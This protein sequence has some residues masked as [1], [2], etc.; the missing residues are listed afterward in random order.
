MPRPILIAALMLMLLFAAPATAFDFGGQL[1]YGD[2]SDIGV[3]GRVEVDTPEL[4]ERSR[5]AVDFNWYFPDSP[6]GGD[7][8]FWEIDL[9]WLYDITPE[10]SGYEV[11]WY[12]G[13]GL[14]YAYADFSP[15]GS[16][17]DLGVNLLGGMQVPAGPFKAIGELRITLAGSEQ[18]TLAAGLLF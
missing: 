15:G 9:D 5:L 17:K 13:G 8:D 10:D 3:G 11:S 4:L 6:P 14:N 2:D 12:V 18:Y 16:E 1:I 7:V